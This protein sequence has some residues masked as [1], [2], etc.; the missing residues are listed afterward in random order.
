[1]W[2]RILP[3]DVCWPWIQTTTVTGFSSGGMISAILGC[4]KWSLVLCNDGERLSKFVRQ[5]RSDIEKCIASLDE[6]NAI[7]E[8]L[9][10]IWRNFGDNL[11][12]FNW[13]FDTESV[14][15]TFST[16]PLWFSSTVNSLTVASQ[17]EFREGLENRLSTVHSHCQ[18]FNSPNVD[19]SEN[20]LLNYGA[21]AGLNVSPLQAPWF[22]M[23]LDFCHWMLSK[24]DISNSCTKHSKVHQSHQTAILHCWMFWMTA[25]TD[26][27]NLC[28]CLTHRVGHFLTSSLC[29]C[30]VKHSCHSPDNAALSSFQSWRTKRKEW[31][32][33]ES[34]FT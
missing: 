15:V 10:K 31:K 18:V 4:W 2:V 8:K 17:V 33:D 9:E 26:A 21:F 20:Q 16:D 6:H 23:W 1:M 7:G 11:L 28:V 19:F 29:N 22:G 14:T 24:F 34:I 5:K 32:F 12:T 30:R 27:H 13:R 3:V 25:I